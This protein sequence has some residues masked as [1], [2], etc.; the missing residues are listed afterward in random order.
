MRERIKELRIEMETVST[1]KQEEISRLK[2]SEQ[3]LKEQIEKQTKENDHFERSN[4]ELKTKIKLL[5]N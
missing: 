4:Q 5:E 2:H 3:Q 1:T